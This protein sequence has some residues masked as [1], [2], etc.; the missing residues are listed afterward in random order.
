MFSENWLC[1]QRPGKKICEN[2]WNK[3]ACVTVTFINKNY[4]QHWYD[5]A[6]IN[7]HAIS[8]LSRKDCGYLFQDEIRLAKYS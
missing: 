1:V 2:I 7:P 8:F 5:I 4:I 6:L 3:Y